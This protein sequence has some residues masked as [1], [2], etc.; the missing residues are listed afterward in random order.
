MM[1][2][3]FFTYPVHVANMHRLFFIDVRVRIGH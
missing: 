1:A 3:L 2:I